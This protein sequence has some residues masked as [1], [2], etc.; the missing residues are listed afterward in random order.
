MSASSGNA[1]TAGNGA[2]DIVLAANSVIGVSAIV[3]LLRLCHGV[4]IRIGSQ[5]SWCWNETEAT[6]NRA[7]T[8]RISAR[9]IPV[10]R[11]ISTEAQAVLT[12][13]VDDNG[14]PLN[15]HH[16]MPAPDDVEGWMAIKAMADA[17]YGAAVALLAGSVRSTVETVLAETA[18]IHVATP[19]DQFDESSALIDLHGGALIVGGGEACRIG[20]CR[21]ADQH[22]VRCY[23]I[24]YRMPPEYPFP[25]ALD[26]CMAAYRQI[27]SRHAADRIIICGRSAGGNLAAAMLLRAKDEGFPMPGGLVL[28]SPE[29][30]LTESGDSFE[31]NQLTDV[32]LPRS[33]RA[34]NLLY[35]Q[36][37][38]LA[39]P[40]LSPLFGDLRGF[41]ATFL[42]SGTRDLFLSNT[43][44]MHRALHAAAVETE[45]H[46][47]EAMPHGGFMG[48]TPEDRELDAEVQ[49]FVRSRLARPA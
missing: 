34:N 41:P 8:L 1:A 33:L 30:D 23:A 43:V 24:D 22:N 21:Q 40:Y 19:R 42:Q 49:R 7:G 35:A 5:P 10:P 25:A 13:L 14:M 18:T 12:R 15:A 44:R 9:D 47:F 46:V 36:D 3:E 6:M 38:D 26:D 45:L 2:Q 4:P 31:T 48:G 20:A 28:L 11:S 16:Q 29:V 39:D 17:H 32:V 37:A 27:L